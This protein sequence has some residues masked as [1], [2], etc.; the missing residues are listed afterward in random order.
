MTIP[1]ETTELPS[2]L[3]KRWR[4][5]AAAME[6]RAGELSYGHPVIANDYEKKAEQKRR[7]ADDLESALTKA[8]AVE[9]VAFLRPS[10]LICLAEIKAGGL[11]M[12][13]IIVR[14]EMEPG[15]SSALYAHAPPAVPVE[16]LGRNADERDPSVF[17]QWYVENAPDFEQNPIGTRQCWLMRKAW[18]AACYAH[19]SKSAPP[20]ASVPDGWRCFHCCEEFT[21]RE[22]AALHFGT[23]EHQEP[24]CLINIAKFRE[25]EALQLRYVDEDADVHRAMRRMESGHQQALRRAEEDGYAKGLVDAVKYPQDATPPTNQEGAAP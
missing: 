15:W 23:H 16:S 25:M 19:A 7:C 8:E 18:N 13:S 11:S 1:T 24:A 22:S 20:P 4:D 3:V 9:P 2:T 5:E 21:D 17:E 6:K 14:L 12:A 10:D